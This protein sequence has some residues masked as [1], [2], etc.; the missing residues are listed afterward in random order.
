[1]SL[2]RIGVI[3]CA[4]IARRSVVPAILNLTD[5]YALSGIAS[6]TKEKA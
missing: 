6:R 2:V 5:Q 1:M 4:D 3:G